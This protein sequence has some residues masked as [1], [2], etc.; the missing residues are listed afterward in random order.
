MAF[1]N[2]YISPEDIEKYDIE[3]ISKKFIVGGVGDRIWTIDRERN[4]YLR[5]VAS[6]REEFY[7]Q[8]TWTFYWHGEL[9]VFELDNIGSNVKIEGEKYGHKRIWGIKIPAHLETKRDEILTDLKE[10]LMAYKT[11]GVYSTVTIYHLTLD[12]EK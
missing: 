10:A 8:S 2:E 4:I 11:A 3:N 9:I 12:I 1:V 6:G 7:Y 5:K